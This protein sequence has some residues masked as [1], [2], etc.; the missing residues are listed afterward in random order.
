[1]SQSG[2]SAQFQQLA[3]FM[4]PKE[5]GNLRAGDNRSKKVSQSRSI[6]DDLIAQGEYK[7]SPSGYRDGSRSPDHYLDALAVDVEKK[8]GVA[9][10]LH[11]WHPTNGDPS[12]LVDGHHRA[13]VAMNSNRLVPVIHHDNRGKDL[14]KE[15]P[16]Y[17]GTPAQLDED[18]A[19][20][21]TFARNDWSPA[22]NAPGKMLP[23]S[24]PLYPRNV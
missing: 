21:S 8:G 23:A 9:E 24:P 5:L 22:E 1:M 11:V 2:S 12:T 16:V 13:V 10:P 4:T 18:E 6:M 19:F 15:W 3:M 7:D 14:S 17:K 20:T